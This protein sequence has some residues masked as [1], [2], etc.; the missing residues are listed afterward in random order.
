VEELQNA[1]S[2]KDV[3]QKEAFPLKN[4]SVEQPFG[5]GLLLYIS[6]SSLH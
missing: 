3:K 2:S 6:S 5:G 4:G 1:F